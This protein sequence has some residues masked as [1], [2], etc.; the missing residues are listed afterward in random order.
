MPVI[1]VASPKG[2]VG[3]STLATNIAGWWARQ[4]HAV[5]L[6]DLPNC[7]TPRTTCTW[8]RAA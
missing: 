5:M 1:V 6:G 4:G 2:G 7:A 8:P 3:K